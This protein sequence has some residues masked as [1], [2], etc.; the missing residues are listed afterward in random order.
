MPYPTPFI[1]VTIF[2]RMGSATSAETWSTSFKLGGLADTTDPTDYLADIASDVRGFHVNTNVASGTRTYLTELHGAVIGTD[3]KYVGG[4]LQATKIYTY[5][6]ADAG[7]GSGSLPWP[8]A[9]VL[10]LRVTS[11]TRGPAS[12]GRMYWPAVGQ[13]IGLTDGR[14]TPMGAVAAA[15][16]VLLTALNVKAKTAFGPGV[17]VVNTSPRGTGVM[18][19]VNQVLVGNRPDHQERRENA[20]A[21]AY[22]SASVTP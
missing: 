22:A 3:G 8:T 7:V 19:A 2:G 11:R 5:P 18:A 21:E 13:T 1:R 10:S 16:G 9:Q 14:F 15:A 17:S 12:H 4:A 20:F 6:T